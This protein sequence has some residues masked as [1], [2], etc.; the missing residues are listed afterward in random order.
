MQKL[1]YTS[2]RQRTNRIEDYN[3]SFPSAF[4]ESEAL[5]TLTLEFYPPELS[6]NTFLL[7]H[8]L[9]GTFLQQPWKTN[10]EMNPVTV[11]ILSF[12]NY[13]WWNLERKWK[14]PMREKVQ[15]GMGLK[16][17]RGNRKTLAGIK[18]ADM[19]NLSVPQVNYQG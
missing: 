8:S 3:R 12:R 15:S 13:W 14:I 17:W 2:T 9:C 4:R 7:N 18:L 16:S 5:Q 6:G 10:R 11:Q 1:N 19:S